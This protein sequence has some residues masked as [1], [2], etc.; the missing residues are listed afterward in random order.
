[1]LLKTSGK[2]L[3]ET[4]TVVDSIVR[5]FGKF[6]I[7]TIKVTDTVV[8]SMG[9]VFSETLT[10]TDLLEFFKRARGFIRGVNKDTN[11]GIGVRNKIHIGKNKDTNTGIG[12][13]KM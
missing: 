7:E 1:M 2:V 13:R 10:I 12:T 3:S 11:T 9:R 8:K 4:V 5:V 6:Y